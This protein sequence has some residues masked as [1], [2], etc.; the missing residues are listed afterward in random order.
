[1]KVKLNP[2]GTNLVLSDKNLAL[3]A[4]PSAELIGG[5]QVVSMSGYVTSPVGKKKIFV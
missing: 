1:M 2:R 5:Q 4:F 3:L